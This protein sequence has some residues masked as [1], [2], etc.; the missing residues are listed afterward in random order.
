MKERPI[1]REDTVIRRVIKCYDLAAA[2]ETK[3]DA[4]FVIHAEEGAPSP[5]SFVEE[6]VPLP[7]IIII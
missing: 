6:T 4:T 3:G 5:L 1:I 2:S 7:E